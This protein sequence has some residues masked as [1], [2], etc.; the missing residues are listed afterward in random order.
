MRELFLFIVCTFSGVNFIRASC[1]GNGTSPYNTTSHPCFTGAVFPNHLLPPQHSIHPQQVYPQS[2]FEFPIYRP[3]PYYPQPGY[4]PGSSTSF[5][6][7]SYQTEYNPYYRPNDISRLGYAY[8]TGYRGPQ[9]GWQPQE[10]NYHGNYM[11][12]IPARYSL[13]FGHPNMLPVHPAFQ[14]RTYVVNNR[15][16]HLNQPIFM[17]RGTFTFVGRDAELTCA[18][19][20]S[21][22]RLVSV[23]SLNNSVICMFILRFVLSDRMSL[24]S[25]SLVPTKQDPCIH[26]LNVTDQD[27]IILTS[28]RSTTSASES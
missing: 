22:Y 3:N 16:D 12:Q 25:K 4:Q 7:G 8:P 20:D 6:P 18:F 14:K 17:D 1:F 21:R 26:H 24:G 19:L 23:S 15:P 2:P 5:I 11:N 13:T 9:F 27:V 10:H 28:T